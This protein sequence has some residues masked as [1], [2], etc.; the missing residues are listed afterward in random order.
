MNTPNLD[1]PQMPQNSLQPSVP[2]NQAMQML[3]AINPLIVLSNT[4]SV[5]PTTTDADAGKRW[6]VGP[7][8]T[9][10]WAGHEDDIA[11]CTGEALWLYLTPR[12]GWRGKVLSDGLYY[13][14][15]G[16]AWSADPGVSA[17]W[18][19]LTGALEDQVDLKAALDGKADDSDLAPLAA[20]TYVDASV[21]TRQPLGAL[22]GLNDQTGTAYTVA[23]SDAGKEVRCTNAAA[24]A[25][26]IDTQANVPVDDGFWCLVSQGG[27]GA[28]TVTALA[29]VTLRAPNG[30]DT[31]TQYDARGVQRITGDTWR[32]W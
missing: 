21:A 29:G 5:P 31:S 25:F 11:L 26:N 2:F 15:T 23:A 9:G 18:G 1:L 7:T 30:A 14:F 16:S 17:A 20:T 12:T 28:V 32:V 24:V 10:E 8:A 3:D 19:S 27:A 6:I 22:S 13:S 4:V